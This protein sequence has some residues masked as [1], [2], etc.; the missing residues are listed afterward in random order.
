MVGRI[1][2]AL[3][4]CRACGWQGEIAQR[5]V[6]EYMC[7]CGALLSQGKSTDELVTVRAQL[8]QAM[9]DARRITTP[10]DASMLQRLASVPAA[11]MAFVAVRKLRRYADEWKRIVNERRET[12]A[13]RWKPH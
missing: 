1:V 10:P 12:D 8:Q 11:F 3:Y 5:V 6:R 7:A 9:T 4:H 2:N 13:P